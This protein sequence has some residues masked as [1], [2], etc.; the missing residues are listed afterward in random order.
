MRQALILLFLISSLPLRAQFLTEIIFKEKTA[1]PNSHFKQIIEIQNYDSVEYLESIIQFNKI[2]QIT[3]IDTD[4]TDGKTNITEYDDLGNKLEEYVYKNGV[5][6]DLHKY[7]YDKGKLRKETLIKRFE[8]D[9]VFTKSLNDSIS[10]I[11]DSTIKSKEKIRIQYNYTSDT[12]YS[13]IAQRGSD[14]IFQ[15]TVI[16]DSKGRLI[17]E[18]AIEVRN[19]DT[20]GIERFIKYSETDYVIK[21]IVKTLPGY[22]DYFYPGVLNFYY[23]GKERW[24]KTTVSRNLQDKDSWVCYPPYIT[25]KKKVMYRKNSIKKTKEYLTYAK[26]KVINLQ[27]FNRY[28]DIIQTKQK[29]NLR[30]SNKTKVVYK[31]DKRGNWIEKKILNSWGTPNVTKRIISYHE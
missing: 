2:G 3:K 17:K 20:I 6:S 19:N 16:E 31:Y 15:S 22:S 1:K 24:R 12:S 27:K 23:D 8:R 25:M 21:I 10:Q 18:K 26:K 14:T 29:Q 30:S 4:T 28:G 11:I 7:Y 9:T 5:K 13:K